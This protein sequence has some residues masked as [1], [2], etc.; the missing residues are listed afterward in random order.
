MK[1][2]TNN[3][4]YNAYVYNN[5]GMFVCR[6]CYCVG[7]KDYEDELNFSSHKKLAIQTAN[8]LNKKQVKKWD[9]IKSKHYECPK[10]N[11]WGLD[12]IY[13]DK[14]GFDVCDDCGHYIDMLDKTN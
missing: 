13:V 14:N 6:D 2:L 4:Y 5:S 8:R 9:E 12:K 7:D 1:K 3:E 10:C 11:K